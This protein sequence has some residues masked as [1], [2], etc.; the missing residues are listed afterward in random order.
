V[1]TTDGWGTVYKIDVRSGD[2][3]V[4]TICDPGVKREGNVPRTAASRCGKIS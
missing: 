4:R 3:A 1:Y 2:A